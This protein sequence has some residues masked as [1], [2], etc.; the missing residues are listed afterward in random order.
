[1]GRKI[2]QIDR[3]RCT[4]CEQCV[5]ACIGDALQMVDGKAML[6]REDYCDGL[7]VCIGECPA[8]ALKLVD[9][10]DD[11][12]PAAKPAPSP[13]PEPVA[14]AAPCACPGSMARLLDVFD[15]EE[16]AAEAESTAP[17][18][19]RL[20]QWPI[21]LHLVPTRA[22]F[23]QGRELLVLASC[24]GASA[25]D[26]HQRFLDGRGVVMACPKLDITD[27]YVEKMAAIFSEND[28]PKVVVARMTVPCC[29]GLVRMAL[30]A[31][32]L[33]GREDLVIEE[34]VVGLDGKLQTTIEHRP[35]A[36]AALRG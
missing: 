13:K 6:M 8:G 17:A 12:V 10:P 24:V 31:G 20:A 21:M 4:G 22:P 2:I 25:P 30:E 23:F 5:N 18:R 11:G 15:G 16:E 9:R 7:G 28:I 35:A 26:L 19:S 27:P 32:R 14:P 29:G 3:D 1:M 33:S 34:V 36:P